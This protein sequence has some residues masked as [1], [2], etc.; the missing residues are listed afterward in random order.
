MKRMSCAL[1][2]ELSLERSLP[3]RIVDVAIRERGGNPL[4]EGSRRVG[5]KM[6][7]RQNN[8]AR[9]A[10]TSTVDKG[11]LRER[12]KSLSSSANRLGINAISASFDGGVRISESASLAQLILLL[13]V[14]FRGA[15][16]IHHTLV[17]ILDNM[18][19]NGLIDLE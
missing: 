16:Q 15:A 3:V 12:M 19:Q 14:G 1:R 10:S 17:A 9:T 2:E 6:V 7:V 13:Q 5:V 8:S 11:R 4:L 18:V